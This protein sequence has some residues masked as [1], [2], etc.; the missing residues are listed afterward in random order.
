MPLYSPARKNTTPLPTPFFILPSPFS[1]ST[2]LLSLSRPQSSPL[3]FSPLLPPGGDSGSSGPRRRRQRWHERGHGGRLRQWRRG[4]RQATANPRMDPVANR[5]PY[6]R[7]P[8]HGPSLPLPFLPSPSYSEEGRGVFG[9]RPQGRRRW[10]SG[11][12]ATTTTM[13][14]LG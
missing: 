7:D 14:G 9:R 3:L 13:V 11:R 1:F 8:A 10:A 2:H 4:I 5:A 6:V 12:V